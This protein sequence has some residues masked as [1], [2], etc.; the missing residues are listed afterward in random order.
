V[1]LT[2]AEKEHISTY[3]ALSSARLWRD[4][5][6]ARELKI[7]QLCLLG[8]S[9][10]LNQ[11]KVSAANSSR[12]EAKVIADPNEAPRIPVRRQNQARASLFKGRNL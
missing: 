2:P 11:V 8:F 3:R 1:P 12:L 6:N 10:T 4:L 5:V 7:R 9:H